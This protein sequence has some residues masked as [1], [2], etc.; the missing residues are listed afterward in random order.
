MYILTYNIQIKK[1]SLTA[2]TTL[3]EKKY[4]SSWF[5]VQVLMMSNSITFHTVYF[6]LSTVPKRETIE[7]S[8]SLLS[9]SDQS[10][11]SV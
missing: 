3:V 6:E 5:T 11:A 1:D 8:R 10:F 2:S 7:V 9:S 4:L